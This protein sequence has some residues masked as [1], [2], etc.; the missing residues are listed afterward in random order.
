[1]TG[2]GPYL[3]AIIR[4][5]PNGL[6]AKSPDGTQVNLRLPDYPALSNKSRAYGD[7]T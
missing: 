3:I 2:G 7:S 6:T 4:L 5:R 1:V